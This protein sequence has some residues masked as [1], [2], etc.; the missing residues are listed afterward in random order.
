LEQIIDFWIGALVELH[1]RPAAGVLNDDRHVRSA[2][3]VCRIR[4]SH[5]VGP[6]FAHG[7]PVRRA[8]LA[9]RSVCV[10]E[11]T[12][13]DRA[14]DRGAV[15]PIPLFFRR[16]IVYYQPRQITGIDAAG[17][18]TGRTLCRQG[19]GV[20]YLHS[21]VPPVAEE[22]MAVRTKGKIADITG[23][24]SQ[25]ERVLPRLYIPQ[26]DGPI[27]RCAGQPFP[28]RA[29]G[30][31]RDSA[32]VAFKSANLLARLDIPQLDFAVTAGQ[33]LAVGAERHAGPR[34][35]WRGAGRRG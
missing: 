14:A 29:I 33:V 4:D 3:A 22:P 23:V 26:L 1:F 10:V 7:K 28:I 34:T 2:I 11:I 13:A 6:W 15:F 35:R 21:A 8:Q 18:Q 17:F 19:S 5:V 30:Q 31:A 27:S 20:P 9:F 32:R 25:S 24:S 16:I 12:G